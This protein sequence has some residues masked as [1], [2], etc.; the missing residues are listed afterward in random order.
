[1]KNLSGKAVSE[2]NLDNPHGIPS[3]LFL[4]SKGLVQEVGKGVSGLVTAP[5]NKVRE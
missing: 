3:G 2:S 4:G 1:M 5:V